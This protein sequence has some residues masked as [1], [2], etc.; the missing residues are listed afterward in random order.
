MTDITIV[1]TIWLP[2]GKEFERAQEFVRASRS[3]Q[4]HLKFDG[5]IHLH[6]ADDGS[7]DD[8]N[9]NIVRYIGNSW[10]LGE[11]GWSK[12]ERH[13]V[14]ASLNTGLK[15][16]FKYSPIVLHAVDDWEILQDL[17]LNKW[18]EF[19]EDP[20]YNVGMLR[21]FGHPDLTGTVKHIP[22]Y[23]WAINLD[24]HHYV[25]ATRPCLW[26]KRLF[27]SLGY[28]KEDVSAIEVEQDFNK[29]VIE[30]KSNIWMA[31]PELWRHI[32]AESYSELVPS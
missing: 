30:R 18:V 20:D 8:E 19:M 16:S 26:H 2:P 21:F 10:G 15:Q 22:P 9:F 17:D 24:H 14:G 3:W 31:I 11:V 32:G 6:I 23:G 1:A 25:F 28:F 29:R 5:N 12:Q 7:Q 27:D 4:Q 13:G